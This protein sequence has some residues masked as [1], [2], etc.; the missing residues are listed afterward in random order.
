MRHGD[1]IHVHAEARF[2]DECSEARFE[3]LSIENA[4]VISATDKTAS[5]LLIVLSTEGII[6]RYRVEPNTNLFTVVR[7]NQR[8]HD[9]V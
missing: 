6:S 7:G 8:L 3:C 2:K 9:G 1:Y 4:R 5:L